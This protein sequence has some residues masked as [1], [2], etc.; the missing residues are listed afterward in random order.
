MRASRRAAGAAID[1]SR[2]HT[3]DKRA[4]QVRVPRSDRR[5]AS[6]SRGHPKSR[7]CGKARRHEPQDSF[8][9]QD[10][11]NSP[12]R[13]IRILRSNWNRSRFATRPIFQVRAELRLGAGRR[14]V[15]ITITASAMIATVAIRICVVRRNLDGCRP[16]RTDLAIHSGG[17]LTDS[18]FGREDE[19]SP[20]VVH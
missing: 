4:V 1:S 10:T 18:R 7:V 9:A 14:D 12:C 5:E 2:A 19:G 3:I 8:H 20:G 16:S 13:A 15:A 6:A 11:G 17:Q